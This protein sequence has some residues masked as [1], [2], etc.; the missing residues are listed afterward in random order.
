MPLQK[1]IL[2]IAGPTASG[3]SALAVE[4]A[5]RLNTAVISADSRQFYSG[6]AI[7]TGQI[8]VEEQ[9]GVPHFF[10]DFLP[11]DTPYSAGQF[12]TEGLALI[13]NWFKNND[14]IIVTGGSGLYCRALLYGFNPM[15]EVD[16]TLRA[17]LQSELE[18]KGLEILQAELKAKDPETWEEIDKQ[19]PRRVTRALELIRQTGG[20]IKALK[21][22]P[23]A[24]RP[25]RVV[26]LG[27]EWEREELYQRINQRVLH[28]L[29]KGW[30]TE[31]QTLLN[32]GYSPNLPALRAVGY[33]EIF[34]ILSGE[35]NRKEGISLIQQHTRNYAKRQMTWLRK[36]A[37]IQWLPGHA[38]A[39]FIESVI[40]M[41]KD[42]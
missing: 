15:P 18:Q 41:L 4:L 30:E 35:L 37:G 11:P 31:A 17:Q 21:F 27:I 38:P 12:E 23:P 13:A 42:E 29:E 6:M 1:T 3:K 20:P 24:P 5:L 32:R 16:P 10:L 19:N 8:P 39:A 9:K 14:L 22:H 28:M 7:G 2:Y 25:F 33:P 40:S 26:T 36:E 34:A